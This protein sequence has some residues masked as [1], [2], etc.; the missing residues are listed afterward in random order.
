MPLCAYWLHA[1]TRCPSGENL[2]RQHVGRL[3]IAMQDA[4]FVRVLDGFSDGLE[5]T[6][7]PS[8]GQRSVG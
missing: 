8:R 3:Q 4:A 5:V 6:R 2:T 1:S 7:G